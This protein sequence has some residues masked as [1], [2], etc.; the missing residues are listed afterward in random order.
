MKNI[1]IIMKQ[2]AL[3]NHVSAERAIAKA[4]E[5]GMCAFRRGGRHFTCTRSYVCDCIN[6]G[7]DID[8]LADFEQD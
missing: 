3:W 7:Q 5:F 4:R 8:V 6:T 2:R 1:S